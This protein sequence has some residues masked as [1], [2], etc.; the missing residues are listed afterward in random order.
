MLSVGFNHDKYIFKDQ[1]DLEIFMGERGFHKDD[2][3]W[4][5]ETPK[6]YIESIADLEAVLDN[7]IQALK[8]ATN[9]GNYLKGEQV[10]ANLITSLQVLQ[11]LTEGM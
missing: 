2:L 3:D 6:P 8:Q 1:R 9:D 5:E 4:Y 11:R 10:C 7:Q